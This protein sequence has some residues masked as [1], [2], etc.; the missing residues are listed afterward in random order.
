MAFKQNDKE[1]IGTA[2]TLSFEHEYICTC[3]TVQTWLWFRRSLWS[4]RCLWFQLHDGCH[5]WGGQW[6]YI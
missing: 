5:G 1:D 4:K 2:I 6:K 3:R